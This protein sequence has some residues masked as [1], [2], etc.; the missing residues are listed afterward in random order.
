MQIASSGSALVLLRQ[1]FPKLKFHELVS[2]DVHYS[3]IIPLILSLLFQVPKFLKRIRKEHDQIEKIIQKE[4]IDLIISDNRFGCW[5][6]QTHSIFITHQVNL[7]LPWIMK[8]TYSFV[9]YFNHQ[10]IKKF[11]LC[12]IP[13]DSRNRITGELSYRSGLNARYIGML[14]RFEKDSSVQIKYDLLILLSGPEPQRTLLE[15]KLMRKLQGTLLKVFFV[16]GILGENVL[17]IESIPNVLCKNHLNTNE[18]SR[19]IQESKIIISRSG[20]STIMDL[21]KLNKKAIFIPTPGQTEQMYLARQLKSRKIAYCTNIDELDIN[22]AVKLSSGYAGFS[23]E[24]KND[25]L[26]GAINE[27]LE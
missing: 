14:S 11:G 19:V 13:D 5:S 24:Y 27:V 16:R 12:W 15:Q 22:E 6:Q 25:L 10:Q 9:N 18:L 1:E 26:A 2:Y 21:A 7:Q 23:G 8:W 4:K 17:E 20:Y 3:R